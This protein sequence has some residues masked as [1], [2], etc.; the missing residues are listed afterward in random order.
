MG[1][2]FERIASVFAEARKLG[3]AARRDYLEAA[4]GANAR[5]REEVEALLV[6][7]DAAPAPGEPDPLLPTRP[8][9]A[10]QA[11]QDA[12][13]AEAEWPRIEGFRLVRRLAEG[14]MGTV[15]V[16]EQEKPRRAVALKVL[17]PEGAT[18]D[19][20]RRFEREAEALARLDHPGIA[21]VL[22]YGMTAGPRAS[23]PFIAMEFVDGEPLTAAARRLDLPHR[24]RL[25]AR[26][27]EAVAHAHAKSVIHRDLKPDNILVPADGAPK[28]VDFGVA[29]LLDDDAQ[30]QTRAGLVI[31]TLAYMSPEQAR[32]DVEAMDTRSDVYSLGV[33]AYEVLCGR[34]PLG[35]DPGTFTQVVRRIVGEAPPDPATVDPRLSG[36]LALILRKALAKEP[37]QRY[38]SASALAEDLERHL[39]DEPVLARPLTGA[40]QLRWFLRRHK[41]AV[42]GSLVGLA[43]LIAGLI[44][45]LA[46]ARSERQQRLRADRSAEAMERALAQRSLQAAA[47]A[48]REHET[49][50]AADTLER[51]P[52]RLR[53]WEWAYLAADTDDSID[54]VPLELGRLRQARLGNPAHPALVVRADHSVWILP[55]SGE[56][57]RPLE[58]PGEG[59]QPVLARLGG[60]PVVARRWGLD[61]R[62]H[63]SEGH[64]LLRTEIRSRNPL[65]NAA[66]GGDGRLFALAHTGGQGYCPVSVYDLETRSLILET[67]AGVVGTDAL[68]LDSK[69]RRL[70]DGGWGTVIRV[71][72]LGPPRQPAYSLPGHAREVT[73]MALS[74][75]GSRLA[76]GSAD[77]TARIWD[78]GARG[79]IL[80]I[81]DQH[82]TIHA[83]AY[84]PDGKRLV[85]GTERGALTVWDATDGHRIR[86]LHGHR[87]A[88][89]DLRFDGDALESLGDDGLRRWRV[90]GE[91]DRLTHHLKPV[92]ERPTSYVYGV[93]YAPDGRRLATAAWDGTVQIVDTTTGV[94][95]L[96]L[97]LPKEYLRDVRWSPD[98]TSL[99]AGH[100]RL[101]RWRAATGERVAE[102]ALA[103]GI[104]CLAYLPDGKRVATGNDVGEVHLLD[105]ESLEDLAVWPR[106]GNAVQDLSV[107]PGG[108]VLATIDLGGH[109]T[110][111]SLAD[112]GVV[113]TA[114]A[115]TAGPCGAV[116]FSPD[117]RWLLSG[118]ADHRVRLWD[119]VTGQALEVFEG[120]TDPVYALAWLPD[121]SRFFSGSSDGSLWIWNPRARDERLRLGAHA[122]YV[123]R[124]AVSPDGTTVA[125]ASGDNTVR[126]WTT[127]TWREREKRRRSK[128]D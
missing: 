32:G 54:H 69:G 85:T 109:L 128:E 106:V 103:H 70:F 71:Q 46:L 5:L 47:S 55:R 83:V 125:S 74:P 105:A 14:G 45:A 120:H 114:P 52:T 86:R 44:G 30:R 65:Q 37:E 21:R 61:L 49:A 92:A 18:A 89:R 66:G 78:V 67:L 36:D 7:H 80:R 68:L 91:A 41:R 123:Y 121:A 9:I 20:R 84:T 112:G 94:V 57:A 51:V 22:V 4:C 2:G 59:A 38:A 77:Q 23:R 33:I 88:I 104:E 15:Y 75:D 102:R 115:H 13:D 8:E 73:A 97:A 56:A 60:R 116:A 24:V 96:T 42:A 28:V 100:N 17:R 127:Q 29:R 53:G 25:L 26:I 40:Y 110:V 124:L 31:G 62:V 113:W 99:L 39:R 81:D 79:E 122:D 117:G 64:E 6:A 107:A 50:M 111:R 72:G 98:G 95:G 43:L 58:L 34:H 10:T 126:L 1:S 19:G 48:L 118:G 11:L 63:D 27:A 76:S 35:E 82:G 87:G 90:V 16:A 119:A 93:D 101:A 3:P 108:M 12:R